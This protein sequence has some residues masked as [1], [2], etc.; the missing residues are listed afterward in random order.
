MFVSLSWKN[1]MTNQR[2]LDKTF[3]KSKTT[4]KLRYMSPHDEKTEKS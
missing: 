1:T 3:L 4:S 2:T